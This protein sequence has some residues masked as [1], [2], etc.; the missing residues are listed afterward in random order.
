MFAN[1]GV[2]AFGPLAATTEAK[3]DAMID[4]NVKGVY[5]TV[6]KPCR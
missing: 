3:W 4:I 6:Q 5:F 2:G 1:A